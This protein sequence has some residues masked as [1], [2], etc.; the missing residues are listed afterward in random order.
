MS[1]IG[2]KYGVTEK[3]GRRVPSYLDGP[4]LRTPFNLQCQCVSVSVQP[5]STYR[6]T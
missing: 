1:K 4:F 3:E 2:M 5:V 6:T